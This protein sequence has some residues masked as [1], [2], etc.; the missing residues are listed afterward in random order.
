[1]NKFCSRH[2]KKNSSNKRTLQIQHLSVYNEN[3][4]DDRLLRLV[5]IRTANT[6]LSH[7]ITITPSGH[8]IYIFFITTTTLAFN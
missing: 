7:E 5:L 2:S 4:M 8:N 3:F 1:M 6:L